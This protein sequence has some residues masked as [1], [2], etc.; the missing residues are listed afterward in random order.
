IGVTYETSADELKRIPGIIR[1]AVEAQQDVRFDRAHFHKYGDYALLFEAV[2]YVMSSDYTLHM[3]IQQA[4]NL[5]LFE[6]F[7]EEGID[8]AY[9]AQVVYLARAEKSPLTSSARS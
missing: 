1:E 7:A 2:Y 3:D 9:P 6:R 8:F 4:V 5:I